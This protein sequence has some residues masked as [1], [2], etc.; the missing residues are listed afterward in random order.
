M[1]SLERWS[2]HEMFWTTQH[3]ELTLRPPLFAAGVHQFVR[4]A[5]ENA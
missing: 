2:E 1:L 4:T 3:E 5:R